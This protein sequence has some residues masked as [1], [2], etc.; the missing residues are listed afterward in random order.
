MSTLSPKPSPQPSLK[1]SLAQHLVANDLVDSSAMQQ[2]MTAASRDNISLVR[3]LRDQLSLDGARLAALLASWFQLP[4]VDLGAIDLQRCPLELV[5]EKLLHSR[6]CLP[7]WQRGNTLFLA[8]ADPAEVDVAADLKFHTGQ[9]IELVV[10]DGQQLRFTLSRLGGDTLHNFTGSRIGKTLDADLVLEVTG[11]PAA[12]E[13]ETD[14][15]ALDDKP[16]VRFVNRILSEAIAEEASDIHF[17]PFE[18]FYR[19]RFRRDGQLH[20]VTRPPLPMAGRIAAR[21]KVMARLDISERRV[22][23]DGRIRLR[24]DANRRVDFRVSALP[25]LWGEKLVLRNLD[26][27]NRF[28]DLAGL[29]MDAQQ[30]NLYQAALRSS[31]GLILVTGPTGSGKTQTLYAGLSLLNTAERNIATAEDPVEFNLEGINQV[32]VNHKSGLGFA[33]ILRAFLRQDPD[34]LMVGEIRDPETAEIAIKAAQTGHLVLATLHTNS[35]IEALNRLTNLG[36][37]PYNLGSAASLLLAQR[38]LRRLCSHCKESHRLP[39]KILRAE[40]LADCSSSRP[41]LFQA[42][43]CEH[44]RAGYRGRVGIYEVVPVTEAL[45]Q[46]I[47]SGNNSLQLARQARE[48]G[49]ATLRQAALHKVAQGITSLEE[50]NRLTLFTNSPDVV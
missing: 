21:L 17:E 46:R 35:A 6:Q 34:V 31:Q 25:T 33:Q 20:E 18:K 45:S 11:E 50:A 26:T 29:G 23:Q 47:I 27:S 28:L 1:P 5:D 8:V 32:P 16:L 12:Q 3:Y 36:V 43:G 9:A 19:I 37:A 49:F 4:Y 15:A 2:A 30:L 42:V 24:L 10:V 44:C 22:P 7:L 38:L 13:M 14:T 41:N 48:D 40:G 39:E